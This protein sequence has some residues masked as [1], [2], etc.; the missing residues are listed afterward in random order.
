M[1]VIVRSGVPLAAV[2]FVGAGLVW[3]LL[4]VWAVL[5]IAA[6]VVL[7]RRRDQPAASR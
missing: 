3:T 6:L 1:A 2:G 5:V 7:A 4:I